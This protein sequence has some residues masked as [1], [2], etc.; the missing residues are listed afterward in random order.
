MKKDNIIPKPRWEFDYDVADC[1]EDM[2]TRSVP[3]YGSMRETTSDLIY[4]YVKKYMNPYFELTDIGCS[5]GIMIDELIKRFSNCGRYTGVESSDAMAKKASERLSCHIDK[6]IVKV[7]NVD[8]RDYSF[9]VHQDIVTSILTLQF[10]PLEDRHTVVRKIYDSLNKGG[11][12]ILVEKVIGN[13]AVTDELLVKCHHLRKLKNG[14]TFED[15]DLKKKS[16]EGV[17]VPLTNEWNISMLKNNGF[18]TVD[19]FW[20]NL[21]F[22]G[23]IAIKD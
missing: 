2:I 21:N 15:I 10:V 5:D 9:P 11:C 7:K 18:K 17:L 19:I 13:T 14:Y 1:F 6:G 16:L 3:G 4:T 22:V 8:I 20:K 23:Y 12:F